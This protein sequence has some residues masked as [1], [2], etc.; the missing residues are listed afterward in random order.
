MN[1]AMTRRVPIIL[2]TVGAVA[3][4][5]VTSSEAASVKSIILDE[6]DPGGTN[7]TVASFYDELTPEQ[8]S[9]FSSN[10]DA[11][12]GY[13][14]SPVATVSRSGSGVHYTETTRIFVVPL[15]GGGVVTPLAV[16][17]SHS[18]CANSRTANG[19]APT[20]EGGEISCSGATCGGKE[21]GSQNPVCSKTTTTERSAFLKFGSV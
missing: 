3:L 11:G 9:E 18:G 15:G 13:F 20:G 19:C 6:V 4:A 14:I 10:L 17:C 5:A 21:C 1:H 16:T 2:L 8:R 7:G 12:L